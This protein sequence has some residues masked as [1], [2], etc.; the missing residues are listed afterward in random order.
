MLSDPITGE[1]QVLLRRAEKTSFA[2]Q[3]AANAV[4][5]ARDTASI[6]ALP[7]IEWVASKPET[8]SAEWT[9]WS[10]STLDAY[11]AAWD[12]SKIEQAKGATVRTSGGGPEMGF[13]FVLKRVPPTADDLAAARDNRPSSIATQSVEPTA[14]LTCVD[15]GYSAPA[16]AYPAG[17]LV[18]LRGGLVYSLGG[19]YAIPVGLDPATRSFVPVTHD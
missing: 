3:L 12:W 9:S 14:G 4:K 7:D 17:T 19:G 16:S 8:D 18:Y 2:Q 10:P 11:A 15:V 5:A 13:S 1:R 6:T